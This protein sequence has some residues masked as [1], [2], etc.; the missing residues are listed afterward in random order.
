[1]TREEVTDKS[2]QKNEIKTEFCQIKILPLTFVLWFLS[3]ICTFIDP[4]TGKDL[5]SKIWVADNKLAN[6]SYISN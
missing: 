1:M 4:R 3:R 5:L 6:G 2:F